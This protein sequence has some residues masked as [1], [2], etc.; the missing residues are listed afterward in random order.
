MNWT[1]LGEQ[2]AEALQQT[3]DEATIRTACEEVVNKIC[4]Q[5]EN[6]SS[7]KN[8]LAAVR[9][10]LVKHYPH[11]STKQADYQYFTNSGKGKV[12]RWEHL[13]LKYLTLSKQD[14]DEVGDE[15]RGEW[16][17]ETAT[18]PAKANDEFTQLSIRKMNI[19]QLELDTET[20][21]IVEQAIEQTGMN[22]AEFIQKACRVYAKTVTGKTRKQGED[23]SAVSTEN[24]LKDTTYAT[25]P[26]RV[27]ELTRRAIQ[28]IKIYNSEIAT[29]R[30]D[31]WC[32]TQS[33]ITELT[34]SRASAVKECL[35]Q[36]RDDIYDHHAKYELL[37]TKGEPDKYLNRKKGIDI[38][39]KIK[40]LEL[41]P[42]GIE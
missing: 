22:L 35:E 40:L 34:G 24:L 36:Y 21:G 10:A 29:E 32:I 8:P 1:E 41:V 28:A 4:A 12:E 13:A 33:I 25:H 16:Q 6:P 31:R 11:T 14:W 23:L 18:Q 27:D 38:K 39:E 9:K 42:D 15:K 20:Q 3:D 37:D 2:L 30:K 17:E 19:E 26:G 5:Y 7:R